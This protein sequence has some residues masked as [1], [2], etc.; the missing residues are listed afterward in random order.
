MRQDLLLPFIGELVNNSNDKQ[1]E[2]SFEIV[3]KI[4]SGVINLQQF[5]AFVGECWVFAFRQLSSM[6][7][8]ETGMDSSQMGIELWANQQ[9]SEFLKRM[10]DDFK[11]YDLDKK[12]VPAVY[13]S[14]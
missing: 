1:I 9:K 6:V 4:R 10:T 11:K 14:T 7:Q 3:D 12:G 13:S 2:I 8:Q 5:Q